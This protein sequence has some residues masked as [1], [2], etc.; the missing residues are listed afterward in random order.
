MDLT[1]F[2]S[3]KLLVAIVGAAYFALSGDV[4]QAVAVILG[5]VGVEGSI[6]LAKILKK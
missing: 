4:N 6:D 1:K 3:R 2:I 5:Y